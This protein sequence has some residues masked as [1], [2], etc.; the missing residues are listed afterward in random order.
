MFPSEYLYSF[1]YL[2][3]TKAISASMTALPIS[4]EEY[5]FSSLDELLEAFETE[6]LENE[7][8]ESMSMAVLPPPEKASNDCFFENRCHT[9]T[10]SVVED[11]QVIKPIAQ[12]AFT[13]CRHAQNVEFI[14]T[15]YSP[16]SVRSESTSSVINSPPL[17]PE[18]FFM[19]E[20]E[21]PIPVISSAE[22]PILIQESNGEF[23]PWFLKKACE[24]AYQYDPK[25]LMRKNSRKLVPN[26][27]KTQ[28]YWQKR[29]RN[30]KA[31]RK[32]REDRR[33]KEL[34]VL[35]AMKQLQDENTHLKL[36]IN[37]VVKSNG[38]MQQQISSMKQQLASAGLY[39][40]K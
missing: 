26:D 37:D 23:S 10:L 32:S 11:I 22:Q 18:S 34:E 21:M 39:V 13:T 14:N 8:P 25:P 24:K 7:D 1:Y 3:I 28:K 15:N 33:K 29:M 16:V 36:Y 27:Q 30:N 40:S 17:S 9:P 19:N 2:D 35:Q 6:S 20:T 5:G 31:A 38:H 4:D 12:M